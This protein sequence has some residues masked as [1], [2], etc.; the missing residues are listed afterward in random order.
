MRPRFNP[1]EIVFTDGRK[2]ASIGEDVLVF[3]KDHQESDS[4]K[5]PSIFG[6]LTDAQQEFLVLEQY[7]GTSFSIPLSQVDVSRRVMHAEEL[8]GNVLI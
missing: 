4:Y 5:H 6:R 8:L 7:S 3:I 2:P 1:G